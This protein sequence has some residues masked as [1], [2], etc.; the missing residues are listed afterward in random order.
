MKP[1]VTI[2]ADASFHPKTRMAAWGAWIKADG[3]EA[4]THGGAF[5]QQMDDATHAELAALA[6]A[7][8]VAHAAGL[9][10]GPALLQSDSLHALG[11]IM[12]TIAAARD[13]RHKKGLQVTMWRKAIPR[14]HMP[15]IRHMQRIQAD[16]GIPLLLRHVKGHRPGG[17][18]NRVNNLCDQIAKEERE[19]AERGLI[20]A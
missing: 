1:V 13:Y 5:S 20:H 6:N 16:G 14:S 15:M 17:G 19:K 3:R 9:L 10:H 4:I 2:F 8:T 12:M 18:R 7:L 11:M